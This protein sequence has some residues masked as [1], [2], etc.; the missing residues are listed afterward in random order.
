MQKITPFLWFDNQA[1]EA[2]SFYISLFPDSKILNVARAGKAGP[3]PEGSVMV[4]DF[5][6]AGQ[7]FSAINGGPHFS[8]TPA[9]SLFVDCK[10]QAEVDELWAKFTAGGEE[11]MCGWLRDKYGLSWQ[12]IPKGLV[13]LLY[14]EDTEKSARAMQA[15]LQMR[16]ID[17]AKIQQAYAGME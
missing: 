1:E 7:R 3:V 2:V 12:I 16:K 14:S 9:I 6:L 11:E 15:M 5:Q 17:L 4:I 13:E 10:T 8:F